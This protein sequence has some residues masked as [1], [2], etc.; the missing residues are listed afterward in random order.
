VKRSNGP[1]ACLRSGPLISTV[2]QGKH[3]NRAD[4]N[5]LQLIMQAVNPRD[6]AICFRDYARKI[7]KKVDK[8]DPNLLKLSIACGKVSHPLFHVVFI[9]S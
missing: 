5:L 7:H 3:W 4:Q 1:H 2:E 6:V 9:V 8:D